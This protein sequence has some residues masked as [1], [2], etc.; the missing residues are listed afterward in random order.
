MSCLELDLAVEIVD[1][2]QDEF[3]AG[4]GAQK[5]ILALSFHQ[6]LTQTPGALCNFD[7]L[8]SSNSSP[9]TNRQLIEVQIS[10][11]FSSPGKGGTSRTF[12]IA[13]PNLSQIPRLARSVTVSRLRHAENWYDRAMLTN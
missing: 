4:W 12:A 10:S 9:R 2:C 8:H 13:R 7:R 5:Q 6:Q 1:L 3:R 11:A